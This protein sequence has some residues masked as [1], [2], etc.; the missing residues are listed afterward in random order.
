MW[1]LCGGEIGV[2][3]EDITDAAYVTSYIQ[4]WRAT[5]TALNRNTLVL[6]L[7]LKISHTCYR[8]VVNFQFR[9]CGKLY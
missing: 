8:E 3:A 7:L 9:H 5:V 2:L 6:T 1:R 4:D